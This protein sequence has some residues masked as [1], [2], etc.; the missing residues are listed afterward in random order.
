VWIRRIRSPHRPAAAGVLSLGLFVSIFAAP[1]TPVTPVTVAAA[2]ADAA[3]SSVGAGTFTPVAATRLL[4]TR[5]TGGAIGPG[6]TRQLQV[7]GRGQ[8]PASGVAA[9]ALTVT[10]TKPTQRGHL[11]VFPA[12]RPVPNTSI[13][14]FTAGQ[15]VSN[16]AMVG[17]S[18]AGAVA[19]YNRYG[20][21]HVIVDVA[22]WYAAGTAPVG[23]GFQAVTPQRALDTRTTAPL[24]GN[25]SVLKLQIAGRLGVPADA[26]GVVI[27]ITGVAPTTSTYLTVWPAGSSR[28]A[29]SNVNL[30]TGATVAGLAVVGLGGGAISI[31][32]G[33]S[34][35]V[36]VLV[37]VMGYVA[38]GPA[39]PGGIRPIR[40]ARLA[41]TRLSG[42]AI[43]AGRSVEVLTTRRAGVPLSGVMAVILT[44][45]A[46]SSTSSSGWLTVWSSGTPRPGTSN[47]NPRNDRPV[48]VTVVVQPGADGGVNI[49]NAAGSTHVVIDV[50]AYVPAAPPAVA[51]IGWPA[52][53]TAPLASEAGRQARQIL[54]TANRY[55]LQKWWPQVAPTLMAAPM[56]RNAQRDGA[57]SIRRLSMEAFSLAASLRT[58]AYD[59]AATNVTPAAAEQA[60]ASIVNRVAA[61]HV[62]NRANG[63]G[64]SWQSALWSSLAGRAG[65]LMWDALSPTTQNRLAR[66]IE[67]EADHSLHVP[68]RYLRDRSGRALT[69]GNTGAEE[70]SWYALAPALATAMFPG[71]SHWRAWRH[72]QELFLVASWARPADVTSTALVDGRSKQSWLAGSNVEPNGVVINHDRVAPDYSTTVY[73]SI[74]TLM[75]AALADKPAPEATVAGLA[76][77]YR[78]LLTVRYAV[79]PYLPPGGTVYRVPSATI[80]YPQGCDWGTG[81]QLPYALFDAQAGEFGFD[82]TGTAPTNESV[83]ATAQVALQARNP[84]G[85]TFISNTEYR[86][87][88]REEHTAQLAA[89]LY[90]SHFLPERVGFTVAPSISPWAPGADRVVGGALQTATLSRLAPIDERIFKRFD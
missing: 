57:D 7:T 20:S 49:Y 47:L 62:A 17:L 64:G 26:S 53:N 30:V 55:A 89:Q 36:H 73:Q 38:A 87:V 42:G 6:A 79:P 19:I 35:R 21:V 44:V 50:T 58:G 3:A 76:P 45:T 71:S 40:P 82:S 52:Y 37:D 22:G 43:G 48:A 13:I 86:Y 60:A 2:S 65:W 84:D 29:T 69:P 39:A 24:V 25:T 14:N 12:D 23:G 74:D 5:Q 90:L 85:S 61:T 16:S 18:P 9:V 63:W 80:Y 27:N 31:A 67:W 8:I 78:A 83:H 32:Q 59:A 11:T 66:M 41:D 77:V 81:Q 54:T 46:A 4:D 28:P 75:M 10:V 88:G 33:G 70:D 68:V 34:G 72:R 15:T 51:T 56:D 1:V